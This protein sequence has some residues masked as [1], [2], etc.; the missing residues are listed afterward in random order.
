MANERR[1]GFQSRLPWAIRKAW[2][3]LVKAYDWYLANSQNLQPEG[4]QPSMFIPVEIVE[5]ESDKESD[6][7]D[8]KCCY[9]IYLG[10]RLSMGFWTHSTRD[11]KQWR[12]WAIDRINIED[13]DAIIGEWKGPEQIAQ[14]A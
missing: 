2:P 5:C 1:H 3:L 6:E 9:Y 11:A 10:H 4:N 7:G 8:G 13:D 12:D 14:L